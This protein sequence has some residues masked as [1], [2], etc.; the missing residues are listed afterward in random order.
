MLSAHDLALIL[1]TAAVCT[2]GVTLLALLA[3][4]WGRRRTIAFQTIVIVAATLASVV[5]S[6]SAIAAEMYLSRHDLEVLFWVIGISACLSM[7]AAL[8]GTRAVRRALSTIEVSVER[9]GDGAV[10]AADDHAGREIATL[11]AQLADTSRRLAAARA[12][13]EQLDASRRQFFAWISHDLRTPLTGVSALA[14]SL[15]DGGV[16]NP[17][18]YL[19]RIRTQVS[20][21]SRMVDDL[22]ELSQLQSGA[23][24]LRTEEIVLLD[25]VSDAVADVATI[26]AARG[27]RLTHA[28]VEGQT[29]RADPHELTRVVVNLLS[30]SIRYAPQDSEVL[31]TA[32]R[33]QD[34]LVLSVVDSGSGVK[35]EDL[36]RM[37]EIGWRADTARTPE[38]EAGLNAGAGLGLAIVEGIV[39]AHGGQVS[40]E[41]LERGMRLNVALPAAV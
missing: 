16:E 24:R 29:L 6:T 35:S 31:I 1:A 21:M 5:V 13:L 15:E 4:R 20:R 34:S 26:A 17:G 36:G 38:A 40:A 32:R 33:D 12:D 3:L 28:G 8:L 27:I 2:G 41:K 37:F 18:D 7:A 39:R 19:R 10:V 14:E 30:N 11:S 25:V 22:Y 9:V 23:L